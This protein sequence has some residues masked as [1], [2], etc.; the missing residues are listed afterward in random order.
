[1]EKRIYNIKIYELCSQQRCMASLVEKFTYRDGF[2][3][4]DIPSLDLIRAY[5]ILEV[6]HSIYILN[7]YLLFSLST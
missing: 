4:T 1:M 3:S 7:Y 6:P 2:Q 5:N